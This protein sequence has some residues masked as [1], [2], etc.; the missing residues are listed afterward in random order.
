MS[1]GRE[2][3]VAFAGYILSDNFISGSHLP[4]RRVRALAPG[5]ALYGEGTAATSLPWVSPCH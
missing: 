1:Y 3:C 4:F 5:T 2:S